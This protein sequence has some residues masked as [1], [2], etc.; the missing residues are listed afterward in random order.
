[1]APPRVL[2]YFGETTTEDVDLGLWHLRSRTNFSLYAVVFL[3]RIGKETSRRF[4]APAG[5]ATSAIRRAICLH[6][7]AQTTGALAFL[8]ANANVIELAIQRHV[9]G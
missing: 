6:C 2:Y 4:N 7:I 8:R 9:G 1:M 3:W 5:S